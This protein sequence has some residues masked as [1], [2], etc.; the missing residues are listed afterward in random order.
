MHEE[1]VDVISFFTI[2]NPKIIVV[3]PFCKELLCSVQEVEEPTRAISSLKLP[4]GPLATHQ[5]PQRP[6]VWKE[7]VE[8]VWRLPHCLHTYSKRRVLLENTRR[9]LLIMIIMCINRQFKLNPIQKIK[10]N[11][12][13]WEKMRVFEYGQR[14]RIVNFCAPSATISTPRR[15]NN[16]PCD[17]LDDSEFGETDDITYVRRK[18]WHEEWEIT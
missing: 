9:K 12:A 18:F 10:N 14:T 11:P 7:S 5:W 16:K 13:F 3:L 6:S 15:L 8:G 1:C 2:P 17:N 4:S